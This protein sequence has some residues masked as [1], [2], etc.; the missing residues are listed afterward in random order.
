MRLNAIINNT[1]E[2][3]LLILKSLYPE[4]SR[5]DLENE[6]EN[7]L[8]EIKE[9]ANEIKN[10][11]FGGNKDIF[12]NRYTYLYSIISYIAVSIR[13][14]N[15][16]KLFNRKGYK[17]NDPNNHIKDFLPKNAIILDPK[18]IKSPSTLQPYIKSFTDYLFYLF[19][20]N[21][22]IKPSIKINTSKR[23]RNK[24]K[25]ELYC[26]ACGRSETKLFN[27]VFFAKLSNATNLIVN[28]VK[29]NPLDLVC[30]SC[31]FWIFIS[32][33][34]LANRHK[35]DTSFIYYALLSGDGKYISIENT[36]ERFV[37]EYS[38]NRSADLEIL[39][40]IKE[41]GNKNDTFLG[42]ARFNIMPRLAEI[43]ENEP[44]RIKNFL[45]SFLFTGEVEEHIRNGIIK[46]K[47]D[48][49]IKRNI[50]DLLSF[51]ETGFIPDDLFILFNEY[52]R[53]NYDRSS[54]KSRIFK[55]FKYFL[56]VY[57][58]NEEKNYI[59]E[60]LKFAKSLKNSVK[61]E[62]EKESM[63]KYI[64][65][66]SAVMESSGTEFL[67]QMNT[68]LRMYK[69]VIDESDEMTENLINI[70]NNKRY[71]SE[72]VTGLLLGLSTNE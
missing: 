6:V 2:E 46:Q 70:A 32:D 51:I 66:I 33:F 29:G 60:G 4:K 3:A 5:E 26:I 47:E 68:I 65:S 52:M 30:F 19:L 41:K 63:K 22:L 40:F 64:I 58:N 36:L 35:V 49:Y 44:K 1:K 17:T 9:K 25:D 21:P 8:N 23:S 11:Y 53:E 20:I 7:E 12:K 34:I 16:G 62:D 57:M 39:F 61:D 31:N 59:K 72:F 56:V 13:E 37:K 45:K 18:E 55:D 24:Q 14:E 69:P 28:T 50:L 15:L 38:I 48:V 71:L 27:P 42:Q 43:Y 10:E 54:K 67:R